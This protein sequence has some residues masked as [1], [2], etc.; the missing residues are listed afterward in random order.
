[1]PLIGPTSSALIS[2][3]DADFSDIWELPRTNFQHSLRESIISLSLCAGHGKPECPVIDRVLLVMSQSHLNSVSGSLLQNE[4]EY[5]SWEPLLKLVM[6]AWKGLKHCNPSCVYPTKE[7][8]IKFRSM[9]DKCAGMPKAMLKSLV[10][11][12][13]AWSI[14]GGSAACQGCRMSLPLWVSMS[15]SIKYG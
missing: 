14:K 2:G 6:N 12:H 11:L 4:M 13:R 8:V 5:T 3:K 9:Q 1:M 15:L 10:A 7:S